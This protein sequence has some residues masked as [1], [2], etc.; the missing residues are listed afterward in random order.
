MTHFILFLEY[1]NNYNLY[2]KINLKNQKL[3]MQVRENECRE[4][5]INENNYVGGKNYRKMIYKNSKI[6]IFSK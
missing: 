6:I 4:S 5:R 3:G 1:I 2:V